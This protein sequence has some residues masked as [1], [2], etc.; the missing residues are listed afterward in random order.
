MLPLQLK[1]HA[2]EIYRSM[3]NDINKDYNAVIK[4]LQAEFTPHKLS[5]FYDSVL[6]GRTQQSNESVTQYWGLIVLIIS[7]ETDY[8]N[9]TIN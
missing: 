2:Y 3:S 1:N 9:R 5:Q 4:A 7:V 8:E 6:Y